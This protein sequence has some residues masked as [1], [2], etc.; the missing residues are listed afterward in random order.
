[1]R[2]G[3]E[4]P[5]TIF[6]GK[7]FTGLCEAEDHRAA[8]SAAFERSVPPVARKPAAKAEGVEIKEAA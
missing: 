7:R 5:P 1:L 2:T 3:R 8:A 4:D 6:V